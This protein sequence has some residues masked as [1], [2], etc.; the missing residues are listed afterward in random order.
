MITYTLPGWSHQTFT[1]KVKPVAKGGNVRI[2]QI[3]NPGGAFDGLFG[4]SVTYVTEDNGNLRFII[5]ENV[6]NG[7]RYT[8]DFILH[9][10]IK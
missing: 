3:Q 10:V 9:I 4:D 6:M 7:D 5:G 8:G 2:S 1:A